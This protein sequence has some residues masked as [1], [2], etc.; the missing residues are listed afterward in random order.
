MGLKKILN[1]HNIPLPDDF[2]QRLDIVIAGL[3]NKLSFKKKLRDYAKQ[4][5]GADEDAVPPPM[6]SD[7]EDYLGPRLRWFLNALTTP[8]ARTMLQGVFMVVFFISY[9]EKIPIF[10][11]ILSASLDVLL[12]G[13][14]VLTKTIQNTL[15]TMVSLI[16]LPYMNIVGLAMAAMFGF[17]VWPIVAM[18]SFSRKDFVS[19]IE[20]F[21]RVIPPPV[22]DIIANNFLEGN[23]TVARLDEKR[24]KLGNDI[25]DV[26]QQMS[27]LAENVSTQMKDGLTQLAQKTKEAGSGM[28]AAMPTMPE[29]P[30]VPSVPSV[31]SVAPP[32]VAPEPV[33]PPPVSPPPVAPV[34]PPS[35]PS[36]APPP[37]A[38]VE[39]PSLPSV[40]PPPV[41]PVEPTS[42]PS[43]APP[44]FAPQAPPPV[45][46]E[47]PAETPR[48]VS[49]LDRLRAQ[50]T[51]FTAPR[52]LAGKLTRSTSRLHRRTPKNK[53]WSRKGR[54]RSR[55]H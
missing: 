34:E 44:P 46:P 43:V 25:S 15:P 27:T 4:S 50:K 30:P 9:L 29:L 49:P 26:F 5:G 13:G 7:P 28:V 35:L 52:Q 24:V 18:V 38:P 17:V 31:P 20:S 23:R 42:L 19:S 53:K 51:A 11:S 36:V 39:P 41:A 2:D 10:G 16:P 6:K 12:A 14:K 54:M 45:A 33:A 55:R 40:A 1:R 8:Y 21:I 3:K 48:S 37:V 32:P 47:P 22:G